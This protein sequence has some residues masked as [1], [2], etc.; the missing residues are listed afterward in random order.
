MAPK[1]EVSSSRKSD[2]KRPHESS[3]RQDVPPV[4]PRQDPSSTSF[5]H[6]NNLRSNILMEIKDS[7]ELK[8]PP[9]LRSPPDTR[10]KSKYCDFHRNHGHTMEDCFALKRK[11]EALLEWGF[12]GSYV[13][14]DKHPRNNQNR[15][16]CPEGWGNKQPTVGIINII[17]EGIALGGIQVAGVNNMP[18]SLQSSRNQISDL[19]RT[20]FF[21]TRDLEGIAFPHNDALVISVIIANF[22]VKRILVDNGSAANVLSHET[23]VQ[24]GISSEQLKPIKMPLQGFGGGVITPEGIVGLPLTLGKEGK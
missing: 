5:T 16:K 2:Q 23:F 15:D 18:G 8:W 6:L 14:N 11:I 17:V 13:S 19:Q 10:D 7:K 9:K 20:S 4:K 3:L 22:E 1:R 21:G 24:M 12:L